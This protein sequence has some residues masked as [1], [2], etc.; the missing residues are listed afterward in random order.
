MNNYFA[1][2]ILFSNIKDFS[3]KLSGVCNSGRSMLEMIGVL[4]IIGILNVGGIAGYSKAMEK[5]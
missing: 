3:N 4:A 5:I 1:N 2:S